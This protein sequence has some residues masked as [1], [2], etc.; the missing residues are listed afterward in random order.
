MMTRTDFFKTIAD[1][2]SSARRYA[3]KSVNT[4]MVV[5]YY[6]IGRRIVENEQGG[7]KRAKYGQQMLKDLSVYLSEHCGK[8]YGVDNLRLMRQ[9]YTVYSQLQISESAFPKLFENAETQI[10]ELVISQLINSTLQ[11]S[12]TV[13]PKF[14]PDISWSHYIQ[15]MRIKNLEERRFYE[16]EIA[17]NNW[18]VKEF[19]RQFN[20]SLYER[21]ALS[22]NKEKLR[23]L[24]DKGQIL[25]SPGDLFKEPYILEFT[26]LSE[27]AEY[28]E[29]DLEQKLITICNCSCSNSARAFSLAGVR[30]DLPIRNST[31]G[32]IWY[33][34]IVCSDVMF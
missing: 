12:E 8:G 4:A 6:E 22:R 18:S 23:E 25:A 9:F 2:I 24:T 34:I 14:N 13:F 15:L 29:T 11:I 32:W 10:G 20:T 3:E 33:F 17:A 1:L 30:C 27:K 5:T 26:G 21:L 7:E 16:I 31:F 28:S 19:Q